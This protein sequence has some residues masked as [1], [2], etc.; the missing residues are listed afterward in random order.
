MSTTSPGPARS[1]RY[2]AELAGLIEKKWQSVWEEQETFAAPNPQGP[3]ADTPRHVVA[4]DLDP[5]YIMDMF[6]YP[7]GR[8]L[9]VGH[10]LGYVATDVHG[11]YNRMLGKNVMHALAY[12]A[13]GLPAEQ[14]AVQTGQHP[15]VT[16]EANMANMRTQL[17]SLGLAHDAR[18]TFAT[19]DP[20]F[21]KWTQ[22]IFLQVFNSWFD[23]EANDGRGAARPIG[24]L[25][26]QFANGR[27]TGAGAWET[28]SP[29]QREDALQ[30]YRLAY[31]SESPVN[32]CPG[33]GTVLSNEEVT[34]EGRSERG[35]FP[36]YTRRLRQWNMRITAYADRLVDD[37]DSLDWPESVKQMQRHWI[38]RST[39][40]LLSFDAANAAD[41]PQIEVYTTR[42]DTIFGGTFLVLSPEHP[43]VDA[44][45]AQ[46]WPQGVSA[47]WTG[48]HDTP[49]QAVAA[50]Q[51]AA[52]SKTPAQ[53]QEDHNKTGVFTGSHVTNPATGKQM[54]VF[55]ADY[56]L[57]GYGTGAVMGVPA[58]DTRDWDF[59]KDFGIEYIRTVQ[60]APDHPEDQ[61]YTEGGTKIN[62]ANDQIDL[63]GKEVD[64]AKAAVVEWLGD[65]AEETTQYRLR[66]WLF[67]R[68]RYWGE[69]F[70][71]VYDE[72]GTPIAL[73]DSQ[74]PVD[75]PEVDNFSPRTFDG[76][77]VDSEPEPPLGRND[78]W[79]H[80]TLDLGDG[81]KKYRRETNTMPNW[82]GSSWY[83]LRYADPTNSELPVS[84]ENEAYWLGPKAPGDCGGADLYV[85]GV[86]HAV[87]HLLYARFWHKVLFDLGWISSFEPF[88]KLI[89]Q[90][91]VQAYAFT[92]SRGVYVPA[93]EVEER[94][95]DAGETTWW[96]DGA[97][98][99]REYGKMGKSLKNMVTPDEM[100]E[101]YGADTFRVY[102]MSMGPLEDSRPWETRAV[103]GAQR[104][105]QR[106][107]RLAVDEDSGETRVADEP[108]DAETSRV[109]HQTIA[110]VREDMER[111]RYNTVI[112]KLI[113]LTNHLTKVGMAPREA[114][115]ALTVMLSPFAPHISEEIWERLG[116]DGT[117][118]YMPYPVA[119]ES[120]LVAA[121]VT[122]VVQVRGKVRERIEVDPDISAE[123]LEKL[124]VATDAA[125]RYL[126][127]KAPLKV[128]VRAPKVVNIVPAN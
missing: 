1:H 91:Y 89:N 72:D 122:C 42:A 12:D 111:F 55:V 109:L 19:T 35:N 11:R 57:M 75:L 15:R 100:Y 80:V 28:L 3:L 74:L 22:W 24:E 121:S 84:A 95:D 31:V 104:F 7:S 39:G 29:A 52:A 66:D 107:W 120:K 64:E 18:R 56:V 26:E 60:P 123:E 87:L 126:E 117:I 14:F 51:R 45:T 41:R 68:Q 63:N 125:Q 118:T 88:R 114:I 38:G 4:K 86:E 67:S 81:P 115:E 97:Q 70:P 108:A 93:D 92:D 69:P 94:V 96:Y 77:D 34:A 59:A 62:S 101:E 116:H 44:Y 16:T 110:G 99:D 58:E 13:F 79:V 48:G 6:P 76:D 73:P 83:Q 8:G 43:L 27:D 25:V 127:G 47:Q 17:R 90:G 61:P 33:L 49:A 65:R 23:P 32:W 105:L 103:V 21:V 37:L 124:A 112:A 5:L 82:A 54:P 71:I 78:D 128:I 30:N 20:E 10:P 50:Y 98:V 113:V 40:A 102:E 2:T 36:V 119:D 9:H 85:G 53:R 46:A 106:V